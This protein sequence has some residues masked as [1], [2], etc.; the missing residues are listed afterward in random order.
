MVLLLYSLVFS[1]IESIY[2]GID[3]MQMAKTILWSNCQPIAKCQQYVKQREQSYWSIISTTTS[4][5]LHVGG[6]FPP[7]MN[8]YKSTNET[9]NHCFLKNK[10]NLERNL[11][12]GFP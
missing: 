6:S 12:K 9:Q 5:L 10:L 3:L 11:L 4:L 2:L 1:F 7:P 8:D